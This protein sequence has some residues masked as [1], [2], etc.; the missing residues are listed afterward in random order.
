MHRLSMVDLGVFIHLQL[1]HCCRKW[2]GFLLV[3]N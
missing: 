1:T 3:W 2:S